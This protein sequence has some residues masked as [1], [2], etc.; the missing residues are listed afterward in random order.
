MR[1]VRLEAF[2]PPDLLE[3]VQ[4]VP[5]P[6]PGPGDVLVRVAVAGLNPLDAKMRDGSSPRSRDLELPAVLG[7]EISG[8]VSGAVADVD[9]EALGM[10]I[11]T[12]V[13]GVRGMAD[14]RGTYAEVVAMAAEDLAPVPDPP[15]AEDPLALARWGGL[16]LAGCTALTIIEDDAELQAGASV[17][18][19]GGTGGVGQL[20]LPLL[21]AAG[22]S[23]VLA[24]G[25]AAN[26]ERIREL[27]A[28]PIAHDRGDWV[29][30]AREATGGRGVDVVIDTHF[31]GTFEPSLDLI[32]PGGRIVAVPSLAD[33]SPAT[34]RGIT[35]RITR[36]RPTRERLERLARALADGALDVEI[37]EVLPLGEAARG[38]ELLQQ[39]H[40]RGKLVLDVSA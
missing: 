36:M 31:V 9:L 24:T 1:E 6:E 18:V 15:A 19:L 29:Q 10:P 14:R 4:D 7:R 12:A 37:A 32:A 11:G 34:A 13:F 33:V 22:A 8:W 28:E 35:A 38:H 5:A 27:G 26:A 3:L 16:A 20:L 23:R 40:T 17:L 25:R 21:R 39:G 2:G 30:A